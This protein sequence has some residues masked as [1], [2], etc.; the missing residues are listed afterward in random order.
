[1]Q[2][3][4]FAK[5]IYIHNFKKDQD[6]ISLK[7]S[8]GWPVLLVAL[9]AIYRPGPVGLEGNLGLLATICTNCIAHFSW[10]S[11]EATTS[12]SIHANS[13]ILLDIARKFINGIY[14]F[15]FQ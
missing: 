11:V 1:L 5:Y 8:S 12:F 4:G 7:A 6:L 10:A 15:A 14:Q 13:R 3:F 9:A 2:F